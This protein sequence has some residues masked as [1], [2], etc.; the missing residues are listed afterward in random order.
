MEKLPTYKEARAIVDNAEIVIPNSDLVTGPVTNWTLAERQTRVKI[1]MGVAYGTDTTKALE[2]LM[3]CA[4]EC[5]MVLSNPPPRALFL[6]FGDSS[7]NFELRVWIPEFNDRRTVLSELNQEINN[8]FKLAGIKIP[9][10]QRDLYLHNAS[11]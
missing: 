8:E 6:S 2:I 5:P 11:S 3:S 9:F 10:P 1:P 4:D 7:L